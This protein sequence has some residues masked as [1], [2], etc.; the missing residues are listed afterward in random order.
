MN[1]PGRRINEGETVYTDPFA[2]GGGG[3]ILRGQLIDEGG[4]AGDTTVKV[5]TRNRED[6]SWGTTVLGTLT[7]ENGTKGAV[8]EVEISPGSILEELRLE[9]QGTIS[10][11]AVIRLFPPIFYD[12]AIGTV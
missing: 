10:G 1:I 3:L 12:A 2:R 9:I 5:F 6:T 7:I 4:T 11:W 8:Y